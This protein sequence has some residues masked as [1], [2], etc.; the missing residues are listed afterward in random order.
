LPPSLKEWLPEDHLAWFVVEAVGELDLDA[1]YA[2]YR[3][4]GWGRAAHDP[5]MMVALF[6][7]A[8]ATGVRTSRGIERH[9]FDDVAFRVITANQA[10]DHATIAR[11]RVRHETAN[12]RARRRW[13]GW[14]GDRP[15]AVH[16][17]HRHVDGG[18]ARR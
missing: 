2:A 17:R 18:R 9:R 16:T 12:R 11:F 15:L 14:R 8:Y 13:T 7:Y 5:A 6:I 1:F 4:D 3:Q 10:P